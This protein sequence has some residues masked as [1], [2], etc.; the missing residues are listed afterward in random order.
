MIEL[1]LDKLV[2][3]IREKKEINDNFYIELLNEAQAILSDIKSIKGG[4]M[5]TLIFATINQFYNFRKG[6]LQH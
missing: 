2:I 3:R 5:K 4:E 6:I 1:N